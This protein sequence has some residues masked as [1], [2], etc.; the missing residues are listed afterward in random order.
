VHNACLRAQH[1]AILAKIQE[2]LIGESPRGSDVEMA[3]PTTVR[4]SLAVEAES[5]F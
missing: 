3:A 5:D 2:P 4:R 1:E